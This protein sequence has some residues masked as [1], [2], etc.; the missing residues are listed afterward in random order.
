MKRKSKFKLVRTGPYN[1]VLASLGVK[2]P[3]ITPIDYGRVVAPKKRAPK[4]NTKT[5]KGVLILSRKLL[6]CN[7]KPIVN[8]G[9]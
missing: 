6:K 7:K 4:S 9:E 2:T 3:S 5:K 8:E 1:P